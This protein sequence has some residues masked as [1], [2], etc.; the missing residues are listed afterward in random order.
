MYQSST[1]KLTFLTRNVLSKHIKDVA[2]KVHPQLTKED[3]SYHSFRVWAVALLSEAGK[4]ED[5]IRIRLRWVTGKQSLLRIPTQ[6]SL[7]C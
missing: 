1:G 6:H 5:Y 7:F 3:L 2:L 4:S